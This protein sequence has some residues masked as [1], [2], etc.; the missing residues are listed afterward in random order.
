MGRFT[1]K[2]QLTW[3]IGLMGSAIMGTSVY[4]ESNWGLVIGLAFFL[5]GALLIPWKK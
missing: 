4:L 5:G 3:L 1:F 2:E